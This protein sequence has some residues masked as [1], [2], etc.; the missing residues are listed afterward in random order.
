[1]GLWPLGDVAAARFMAEFYS[2]LATPGT[3][4]A[5]AV[6][7]AQLALLR[8]PQFADPFLWAPFVLVG[9]WL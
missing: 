7:A 5:Q 6:R 9:N 4:R 2:A 8:E 3:S 1:A